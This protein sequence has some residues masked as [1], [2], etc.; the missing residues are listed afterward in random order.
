MTCRSQNRNE[1]QILADRASNYNIQMSQDSKTIEYYV[2]C[3]LWY[4][5][6]GSQSCRLRCVVAIFAAHAVIV[7][8]LRSAVMLLLYP[9]AGQILPF[10]TDLLRRLKKHSNSAIAMEN[11]P[12]EANDT[13]EKLKSDEP[14]H[15][16][17][18]SHHDQHVSCDISLIVKRTP[19]HDAHHR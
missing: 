8:S 10:A 5:R 13:R 11:R 12:S 7:L 2:N 19:V 3:Y 15:R 6:S 18:T 16:L 9:Y 17:D 4:Y 14:F 1:V